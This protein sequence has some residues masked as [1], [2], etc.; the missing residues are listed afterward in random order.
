MKDNP[1]ENI[2]RAGLSLIKDH[3]TLFSLETALAKQSIMPFAASLGCALILIISTWFTLLALTAFG[4][5]TLSENIW[6]S[7]AST[8]GLQL[9]FLVI[10][11]FMVRQF[12][13]RMQFKETRSHLKDY[14]GDDHEH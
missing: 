11:A 3:A 10:T 9:V 2:C 13:K 1:I 14:F 6:I 8:L 4:I 7:L 12:L 5:Y